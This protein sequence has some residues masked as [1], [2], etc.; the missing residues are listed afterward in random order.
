MKLI[1]LL[2]CKIIQIL[3]KK[4]GHG[5]SLPGEITLKLDKNI[6]KK[7][8]KPK[9]IIC[10]TGTTGKTSICNTLT[11]IYKAAGINVKSNIK[12]SNLK[13]GV[14]SLF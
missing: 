5:T 14:T 2:I 13:F 9:T 6:L 8:E 3:L 12:G 1:V 7:I 10:V 4:I 11:E